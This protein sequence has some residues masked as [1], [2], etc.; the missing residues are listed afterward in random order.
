MRK[1]SSR[2]KII[3]KVKKSRDFTNFL[4]KI[5]GPKSTHAGKEV[6]LETEVGPV[7]TL[8]YGFEDKTVKPI[9][10]DLH[11]GGFILMDADS[12]EPMNLIYLKKVGCKIISIDYGKAPENPFPIAVN[13]T[14]AVVK[15]VHQ[16]AEKYGIDPDHMAIGGY[17]A[18]GNL[19]TVTCLQATRKKEFSFVCQALN[20]PP[21]DLSTSPYDKPCPNGAIKPKQ[22]SIYDACYIEQKDAKNPLVSPIYASNEELAGMPDA[23]MILAGR[24]SLHDEGVRYAHLLEQAGVSV[25]LHDYDNERHGF[26]FYRSKKI[27]KACNRMADFL[28][29]H[30]FA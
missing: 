5:F 14:Y 27:D 18:G 17:S 26:H 20:Y 9:F 6:I 2:E 19:S 28:K 23:L 16:N 12:D 15:H 30:L 1:E 7:R 22:A 8:W 3:N 21:L 10:F 13:Q 25:E 29:K 24:D 11:G 4:M